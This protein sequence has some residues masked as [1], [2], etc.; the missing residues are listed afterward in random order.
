MRDRD[1]PIPAEERLYRWLKT[2]DVNGLEVLPHV[3]DLE[4]TSVDR[5]KYLPKG[6]PPHQPG[7][8]DRNGL[9]VTSVARLPSALR[10]NDIDYEFFAVDWPE[11]VNEAHAEVRPGR[12]PNDERPNGDRPDGFKP[13]SSATK[14]ALRSALA[15]AMT[16]TRPPVAPG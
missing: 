9:A 10:S 8:P 4:G 6:T 12:T 14:L 7:H 5:E 3:V 11:D 13:K 2:D 16:V 1:E 15:S